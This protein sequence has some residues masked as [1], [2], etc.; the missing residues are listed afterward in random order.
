MNQDLEINSHYH[1]NLPSINDSDLRQS[2]ETYTMECVFLIP[3]KVISE[4]FYSSF[5][6]TVVLYFSTVF[7][8]LQNEQYSNKAF[9]KRVLTLLKYL[10][11]N[12]NKY[13]RRNL[14]FPI[15]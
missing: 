7:F 14:T 6:E 12:L 4:N 5:S 10:F 9:V 11:I 2:N 15:M 1:Q 13:V 3:A 8:S